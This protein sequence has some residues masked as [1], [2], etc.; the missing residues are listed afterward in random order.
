MSN[1]V[2]LVMAFLVSIGSGILTVVVICLI[3][4]ISQ[5]KWNKKVKWAEE[6]GIKLER[7]ES[8]W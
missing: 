6:R 2:G 5:W 4:K 3:N 7:Y 1:E 8:D